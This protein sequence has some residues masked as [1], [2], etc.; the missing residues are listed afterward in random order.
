MTYQVC[1]PKANAGER[2]EGDDLYHLPGVHLD[3]YTPLGQNTV[4]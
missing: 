4:H 2:V 3:L 1:E